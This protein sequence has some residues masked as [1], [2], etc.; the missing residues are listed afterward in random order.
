MPA[1]GVSFLGFCLRVH[2]LALLRDGPYQGEKN[3]TAITGSIDD[4]SRFVYDCMLLFVATELG[5]IGVK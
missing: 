5:R 3:V 2:L 4:H 1:S